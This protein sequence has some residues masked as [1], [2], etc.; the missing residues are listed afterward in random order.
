MTVDGT[1]ARIVAPGFTASLF[2]YAFGVVDVTGTGAGAGVGA[3][4]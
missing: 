1:R 3:G 2:F 4:V